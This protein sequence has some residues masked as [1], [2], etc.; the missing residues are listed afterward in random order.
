[1]SMLLAMKIT[2]PIRLSLDSVSQ[3][4]AQT[5]I[6]HSQIINSERKFHRQIDFT[7]K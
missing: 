6:K 1:M 3:Y 4:I 7:V 5:N 2:I